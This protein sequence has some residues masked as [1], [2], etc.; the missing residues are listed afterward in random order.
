MKNTCGSLG[1]DILPSTGAS[2]TM[3]PIPQTPSRED[4][5]AAAN[6]WMGSLQA[7]Q[8]L[9]ANTA[10]AAQKKMTSEISRALPTTQ[11]STP[12]MSYP[13]GYSPNGNSAESSN[14]VLYIAGAALVAVLLL[15]RK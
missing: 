3:S 15:K 6:A 5:V 2:I 14:T 9:A 8:R 10:L 13:T 11:R 4:T 12:N 7:F 1:F